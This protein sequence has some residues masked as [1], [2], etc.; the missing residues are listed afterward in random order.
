MII[1]KFS[2]PVKRKFASREKTTLSRRQPEHKKQIYWFTK[3][4]RT[5]TS[6]TECKRA[7]LTV[8]ANTPAP[9]K[10]SQPPPRNGNRC[11]CLSPKVGR[12]KSGADADKTYT[13]R[14]PAVRS[15]R[16]H[17]GARLIIPATTAHRQ[18]LPIPKCNQLRDKSGADAEVTIAVG[19]PVVQRKRKHAGHSPA[20]IIST[21]QRQSLCVP[22]PK[23]LISIKKRAARTPTCG[24]LRKRA[25]RKSN[26]STPAR[27]ESPQ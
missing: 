19:T 8:N 20:A 5:P 14:V 18:F 1:K 13:V 10:S 27:T 24:K 17:A 12:E 23:I 22:I 16:K 6:A 7:H 15:K 21:A 3:A 11:K 9:T 2:V 4:A 26:A 25:S